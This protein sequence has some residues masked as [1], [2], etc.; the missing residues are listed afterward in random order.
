MKKIEE[1][2]DEIQFKETGHTFDSEWGGEFSR[3]VEIMDKT[4]KAYA[5]QAV[6]MAL[7]KCSA[8]AILHSSQLAEEILSLEAEILDKLK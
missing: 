7:M 3:I 5:Q 8:K 4:A 6:T 2:R 1:I